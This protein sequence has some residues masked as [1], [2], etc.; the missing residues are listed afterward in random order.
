VTSHSPAK[1]SRRITFWKLPAILLMSTL[2]T[3][4]ITPKVY[5]THGKYV[6]ESIGHLGRLPSAGIQALSLE[7]KGVIS[8]FL[9]L[10]TTTYFGMKLGLKEDPTPREW[11]LMYLLLQRVTDLDPRFWDPYVF[12]EM[13]LA[14]HGGMTKEVNTLL[15]KAAKSRP[16]DYRPYYFIGFNYYFFN[17]DS[18]SAA[19]Y[20]RKAAQAPTAP[21]FIKGLAAR[22]SLYGNQTGL[23]IAFLADLIRQSHDPK[24]VKY[25]EIRLAALKRLYYLEYWVLEFKK[26]NGK[27]PASLNDLVTTGLIPAI[28]TDPYGGQFKLLPNGR[29]YT[30]SQLVS[31]QPHKKKAG[32]PAR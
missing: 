5:D 20:M 10:K 19:P 14:W 8:D 9:F 32:K 31:L 1:S 11:Q 30:T 6:E 25:L 16:E 27:M 21:Q 4:L 23:A 29:V 22:I 18:A 12:A 3:L 17:R 28:P 13:I 24:L 2:V 7:F 26:K 15:M